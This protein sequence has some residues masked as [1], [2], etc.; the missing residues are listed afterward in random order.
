MAKQDSNLRRFTQEDRFDFILTILNDITFAL[1]AASKDCMHEA[2]EILK[3]FIPYGLFDYCTDFTI[4]E[5]DYRL[6]IRYS[7]DGKNTFTFNLKTFEAIYEDDDEGYNQ[8]IDVYTDTTAELIELLY[9]LLNGN[10][11]SKKKFIDFANR[12]EYS[13]LS[14]VETITEEELEDPFRCTVLGMGDIDFNNMPEL[15]EQEKRCMKLLLN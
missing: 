1:D 9:A 2:A 8:F 15:T 11:K 7:L 5:E 10:K 3:L 4:Y 13:S 14:L 6:L 12:N